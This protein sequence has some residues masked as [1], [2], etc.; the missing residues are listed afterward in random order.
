MNQTLW[1]RLR[2]VLLGLSVLMGVALLVSVGLSYRSAQ[3]ISKKVA[4]AEGYTLINDLRRDLQAVKGRIKDA[5]LAPL[6]KKRKV[7]G[8]R[9]IGIY[10]ING[11]KIAEAGTPKGETLFPVNRKRLLDDATFLPDN[12]LRMHALGLFRSRRRKGSRRWRIERWRRIQRWRTF[13]NAIPDDPILRREHEERVRQRRRR[14][15]RRRM[16]RRPP[17]LI[18]EFQSQSAKL[19]QDEA[20]RTLA[21]GGGVAFALMLVMFGFAALLKRLSRLEDQRQHQQQLAVL[22]EM[23]AVLAHEIRNPLTSLKGHAQLLEEFLPDD[24][25]L[26]PKAERVV[27]EAVR[28]EQLSSQLLDFVRVGSLERKDLN[29]VALL[30]E[31]AEGLQTDRIQFHNDKAPEVWSMDETRMRQVFS[32]LMDNALQASPNDTSVEVRVT[33]KGGKL[34]VTIDDQGEGIPEDKMDSIFTPFVTTKLHGT[35]L[36]LPVARRLVELHQGTLTASNRPEGGA[37]FVITLPKA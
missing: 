10:R 25:K 18:V 30:K 2:W 16:R 14:W 34:Q 5:D 35:G 7:E 3:R 29:P 31:V 13:R 23:S 28:L 9:Y 12:R 27:Q 26:K 21:V 33:A 4:R 6:L 20:Q 32:N 11:H 37:R 22:G 24:D 36:G 19:V 8:V 1:W 17:L 15:R